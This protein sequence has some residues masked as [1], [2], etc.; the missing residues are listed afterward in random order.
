MKAYISLIKK[1]DKLRQRR[2]LLVLIAFSLVIGLFSPSYSFAKKKPSLSK[3]VIKINVKA[4]KKLYVKNCKKKIKWKILS[5]KKYISISK[6]KKTS[7]YIKGKKAGTAKLL[8]KAKNVKLTCKVVVKK[9]KSKRSS[10]KQEVVTTPVP[11]FTRPPQKEAIQEDEDGEKPQ[12]TPRPTQEPIKQKEVAK[13]DKEQVEALKK[14]AQK[15]DQDYVS[16]DETNTEQYSWS[17]DGDLIAIIWVNAGE[18]KS[19]LSIK[20]SDLEKFDKL[21]EL[22]ICHSNL[23]SIDVSANKNL[24]VLNI[25]DNEIGCDVDSI[26]LDLTKNTKLEELD[27]SSNYYTKI[28]YGTLENLAIVNCKEN[29]LGTANTSSLP[30]LEYFNCAEN[31]ITTFDFSNNTKLVT[32]ICS[33]N[34]KDSNSDDENGAPQFFTAKGCK[35]LEELEIKELN[36]KTIDVSDFTKLKELNCAECHRLRNLDVSNNPELEK[37]ECN[38]CAILELDVS[39]NKKLNNL[40]CY[41]N[42]LL[43]LSLINNS[44]LAYLNCGYNDR[45]YMIEEDFADYKEIP[46][47]G[48]CTEL[49]L[50]ISKNSK[51]IKLQCQASGMKKIDVTNNPLIEIFDCS[52][53]YLENLNISNNTK[54]RTLNIQNNLLQNLDI[55]HNV[56]LKTLYLSG[57]SIVNIDTSNNPEL[58]QIIWDSFDE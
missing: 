13:K 42:Y 44:E 1:G 57:N 39:K 16:L 46:H 17:K 47:F 33:G 19:Q 22:Y 10:V 25:A 9:K 50:D 35:E 27:C 32:L 2:L 11:V 51:L 52:D 4:K 36:I 15:F 31:E 58:T 34:F 49:D 55:S 38:D 3:K 23:S 21:Q 54:L 53:N 14:L 37:L 20:K 12:V 6:I 41:N 26:T 56:K 45:S 43:K 5:G 28:N 48:E 30:E 18:M 8:A 29:Y 24:R 7:V 40:N